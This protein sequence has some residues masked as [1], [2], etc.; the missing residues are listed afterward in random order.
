MTLR[1]VKIFHS[2][3]FLFF[4]LLVPNSNSFADETPAG[5]IIKLK[6]QV[7]VVRSGSQTAEP[8]STDLSLNIGDTIRTGPD[9]T[10]S[11]LLSDESMI[12]LNKNTNFVLKEVEQKAGWLKMR[13]IGAKLKGNPSVYQLDKGEAWIRNKDKGASF[14]VKSP[15]SVAGVRGT[16]LDMKVEQ[17][18]TSTL[19]VIEGMVLVKNEF[20]SVDVNAGE[21]AAAKPGQAPRK[22]VLV[23]PEDAVQWTIT[24]PQIIDPKE[25]KDSKVLSA[26]QKLMTGDVREAQMLLTE[27]TNRNQDLSIAWSLLSLTEILTGN[28][29]KAL[30]SAKKGVAAHDSSFAYVVQSYA[31]QANFDLTE[32]RASTKK[33]RKSVV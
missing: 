10:A 26:Y 20:G 15:T 23:T 24:I 1:Y 25:I 8:A 5:K 18:G 16:D 33:D 4:F 6:G 11:I 12:Q 28:T 2:V 31:Y 14:E 19:T 30:E 3:L 21:Q 29:G 7:E 13:K 27:I 9:G 32:A 22:V 17:D